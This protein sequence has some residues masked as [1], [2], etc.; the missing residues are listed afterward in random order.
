MQA[1]AAVPAVSAAAETE[2]TVENEKYKLVFTNKGAQVKHWILKKYTD[3]AGKPLD[4][5]QPQVAARFGLPL[6]LFTYENELTE[7][8]NT[9]A[10]SGFG[11]GPGAGA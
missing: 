3:S 9:G 8:L 10:L 1:P 4:M 2:T 11:N 5:V 7:Q 6:S